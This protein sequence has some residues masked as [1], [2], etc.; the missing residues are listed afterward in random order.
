[1]IIYMVPL[2]GHSGK[3]EIIVIYGFDKQD[4]NIKSCHIWHLMYPLNE[5]IIVSHI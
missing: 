1:M 4:A 5:A 3:H 2:K